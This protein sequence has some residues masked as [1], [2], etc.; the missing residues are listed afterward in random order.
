MKMTRTQRRLHWLF[1][2]GVVT[3]CSGLL[4]DSLTSLTRLRRRFCRSSIWLLTTPLCCKGCLCL[5][6]SFARLLRVCVRS[7]R[8]FW[9]AIW[10]GRGRGY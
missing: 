7:I 1:R 10:L 9:L 3:L 8:G 4:A 6:W 5:R 2:L